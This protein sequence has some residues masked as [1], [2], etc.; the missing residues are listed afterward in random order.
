MCLIIHKPYKKRIP[1]DILER[2]RRINPHGFGIT[3]LD[4]GHTK[5]KLTYKG[6]DQMLKTDSPLVCH[7]R[8]A[9]VGKINLNKVLHRGHQELA[10]AT[11]RQMARER[12]RIL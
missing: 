9:T 2:A 6:I 10:G 3:Y 4:N 12:G 8:Y 1:K 7:F 11:H 5:R